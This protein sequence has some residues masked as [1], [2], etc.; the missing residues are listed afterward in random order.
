[1][2]SGS[3]I[4]VPFFL[5]PR[6]QE[7]TQ[8]AHMVLESG[9]CKRSRASLERITLHEEEAVACAIVLRAVEYFISGAEKGEDGWR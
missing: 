8:K 6:V 2:E 3:L 4:L 5:A 7:K 9:S 1:M